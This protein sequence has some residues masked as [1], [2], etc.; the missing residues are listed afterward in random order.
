MLCKT[1]PLQTA[2]LLQILE[3]SRRKTFLHDCKTFEIKRKTLQTS[4]RDLFP[5]IFSPQAF[6]VVILHWKNGFIDII[7]VFGT[8]AENIEWEVFEKKKWLCPVN[9]KIATTTNKLASSVD[10]IA[11]SKTQKIIHSLT[12]QPTDRGRC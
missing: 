9:P 3:F 7:T 11:I 6:E 10:A 1:V 8:G 12:D 5:I 4:S 2:K